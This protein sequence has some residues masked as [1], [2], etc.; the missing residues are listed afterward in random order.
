M[1]LVLEKVEA[2]VDPLI[3][4]FIANCVGNQDILLINAISR[5]TRILLELTKC[6]VGLRVADLILETTLV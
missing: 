3:G 4:E 2:E 1:V 6:L 5:L